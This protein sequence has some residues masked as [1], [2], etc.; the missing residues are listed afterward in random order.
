MG[1]ILHIFRPF[2][3]AILVSLV[4]Q[5]L[6]FSSC[7]EKK[8]APGSR[9]AGIPIV[10]AI[11]VKPQAITNHL[12]VNGTV[13][14]N[15]YVELHPEASGRLIYLNVPEGKWI[16]EG[17]I[18]ARVNDADLKAQINKTRVLLDLAEKTEERYR[19]L[20]AV[21]GINQ[22]DYDA[23][24]STVNGYKADINYTQALINKTI[25]KAPFNGKVGLRMVSP[26]AFVSTTDVIASMQTDDKLK[27]DFTILS[28]SPI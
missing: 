28:C 5:S 24:V 11:I 13:V 2:K 1:K 14:A 18:I 17:T 26:G 15:E 20:L 4:L 22:S 12:E 16:E 3:A 10:D 23:A 9:S 6:F 21:N 27:I 19:Q 7:K 25:L 8:D